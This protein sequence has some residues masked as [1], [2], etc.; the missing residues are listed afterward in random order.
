MQSSVQFVLCENGTPFVSYF[1]FLP[2]NKTIYSFNDP[3]MVTKITP[4]F[5]EILR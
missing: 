5:A 1:A 2:L 4:V 3:N